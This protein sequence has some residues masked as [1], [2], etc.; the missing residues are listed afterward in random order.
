MVQISGP[1]D[2]T[3]RCSVRGTDELVLKTI[4]HPF[5]YFPD[6]DRPSPGFSKTRDEES[7]DKENPDSI[8]NTYDGG[9]YSA[10][11]R[12]PS[13]LGGDNASNKT[14]LRGSQAPCPLYWDLLVSHFT[15]M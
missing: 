1:P 2:L 3:I 7:V 6:Y 14:S 12:P 4:D 10:S 13:G 15:P 11:T 9:S 8:Y 5:G